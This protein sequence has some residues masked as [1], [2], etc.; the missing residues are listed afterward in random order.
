MLIRFGVSIPTGREGLMVP[1]G[2]ASKETIVDVSKLAEG[3][4]YYSVWGND[5]ITTQSYIKQV[6]PKPSF[7]DPLISLAAAAGVTERV[8]LAS[9]VLVLPWR[10][11][12][13]VVC[14]KQLATLDVLSGGRL[15]L[16]VGT[17]A[18]REESDALHIRDRGRRL[19]EGLR[20]LRE[21]FEKSVA[22][23][24]GKHVKFAD[25]EFYPKPLQKPLPIFIGQHSVIPAVLDRIA[26]F[27]Q[28]WVPG[29]SA[30]QFR[31]AQPKL[32]ETL[33]RYGR[34]LLEIE[35]VREISV[36]L[37]KDREKAVA[38]YKRTP[39]YA[40]MV[41]LAKGWGKRPCSFQNTLGMSLIGT[42]DDIIDGVQ[43]YVDVNVKHFMLNFAVTTSAE[44]TKAVEAFAKEIM[45]SFMRK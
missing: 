9:G 30:E 33:K 20:G 26:K 8:K 12:A 18:Y 45:P 19:D 16:G 41:S 39:A 17:G 11:P 44:L 13:L 6:G 38:K 21:L 43:A 25:V 29:L 31:D 27:A 24:N 42:V 35:L 14:A 4:G 22:S 2:F 37:D 40:H 3:L 32:Q 36:S 15:I 5:H 1:T 34:S 28:G 10:T 23:F 7:Y